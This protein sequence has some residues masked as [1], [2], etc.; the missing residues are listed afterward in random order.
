MKPDLNE[1]TPMGEVAH[2]RSMLR[3]QAKAR[4]VSVQKLAKHY[5]FQ[6][7]FKQL[8]AKAD[9]PWVVTGGAAM[10]IRNQS[11]RFTSDI[12]LVKTGELNGAV[13]LANGSIDE[14]DIANLT[15]LIASDNDSD[16]A[17]EVTKDEEHDNKNFDPPHITHRLTVTMSLKGI[18]FETFPIDVS[19]AR[20]STQ[21]VQAIQPEKVVQGD[22]RLS[23][24]PSIPLIPVED[25]LADKVC[26]MYETHGPSG[27]TPST[28]VRDLIDIVFMVAGSDIVADRL[29]AALDREKGRRDL[30]IKPPFASPDSS[31]KGKYEKAAKAVP[32]FPQECTDIAQA[33][34]FAGKCLNPILDQTR[35]QGTWSHIEQRWA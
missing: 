12:D 29:H 35:V 3:N 23:N 32:G 33:V 10:V 20:F 1:R 19:V 16:Y 5:V 17:F 4:H 27:N 7:F 21:S 18:K 30:T 8:F 15:A 26:A 28:R 6:L 31:W 9:N 2:V 25:H 22:H 34:T 13:T 24:L 14:D 11:N